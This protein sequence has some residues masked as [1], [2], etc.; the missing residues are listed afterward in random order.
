MSHTDNIIYVSSPAPFLYVA[1]VIALALLLYITTIANVGRARARY[2]VM[3]PATTGNPDFERYFRVQQNTLEQLVVFIPALILF[4]A[5][6]NAPRAAA[7]LGAL[8]L[9]GRTWYMLGYYK[10]IRKRTPGFIISMLTTTVLVVGSLA[11]IIK[12]LI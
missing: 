1:L 9:F 7:V 3:P 2:K 5:V 8:W 10:E 6:W 12:A 4:A 11:G